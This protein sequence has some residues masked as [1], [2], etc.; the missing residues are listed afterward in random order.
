VPVIPQSV[1]PHGAA[2]P[3]DLGRGS[4]VSPDVLVQLVASVMNRLRCNQCTLRTLHGND[5]DPVDPTQMP[6]WQTASLDAAG[7]RLL[8]P[9]LAQAD[10]AEPS[11][12]SAQRPITV[13]TLIMMLASPRMRQISRQPT[14][15]WDKGCVAVGPVGM[16]AP[17]RPRS[18]KGGRQ[19]RPWIRPISSI[20][21]AI[22]VI[23]AL[24]ALPK[25]V[26]AIATKIRRSDHS[27]LV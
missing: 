10:E 23:A 2:D 6:G 5:A 9:L 14:L 21:G 22:L 25:L 20:A 17:A 26:T 19:M 16:A 12:M 24:L 27:P 4:R 8:P 7:S 1:H 3:C 18:S 15:L 13:G 11:R